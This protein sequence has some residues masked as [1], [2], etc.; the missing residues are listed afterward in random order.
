LREEAMR[1]IG[2]A[3]CASSSH[4]VG[5]AINSPSLSR[6]VMSASVTLGSAPG[7]CSLL[8]LDS[9]RPSSASSRNMRLSSTRRSFFRLKARAISRVPTLP[10]CS[11]M[12]ARISSLLGKGACLE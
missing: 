11:P 9:T 8:R 3:P 1:I 4:S 12:K 2:T 5:V 7:W 6:L 10:G